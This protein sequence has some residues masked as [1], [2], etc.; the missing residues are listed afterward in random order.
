MPFLQ[1]FFFHKTSGRPRVFFEITAGGRE[2]INVR[3]HENNRAEKGK[4][5]KC[6]SGS[7][8]PDRKGDAIRS[9]IVELS[10]NSLLT[11]A[12]WEVPC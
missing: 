3:W 8:T 1:H 5:L 12:R 6:S 9:S 11:E 10:D 7:R 4:P 2:K